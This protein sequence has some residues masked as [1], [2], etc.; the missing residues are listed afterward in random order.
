MDNYGR[1][2]VCAK[3]G[4]KTGLTS[5][6]SSTRSEKLVSPT[7]KGSTITPTAWQNPCFKEQITIVGLSGIIPQIQQLDCN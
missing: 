4:D 6:I 7:D 5:V 1:A 2:V 3:C